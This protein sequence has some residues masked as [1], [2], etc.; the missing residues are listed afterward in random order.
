LAGSRSRAPHHR[1][2]F[3]A[4][5]HTGKR[6]GNPDLARNNRKAAVER[7]EAFRPVLVETVHLST[8]PP[9]S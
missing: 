5:R 8:Q 9:T 1:E 7:A 4:A 6:I 3:A 2:A